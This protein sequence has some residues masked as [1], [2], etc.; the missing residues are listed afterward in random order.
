MRPLCRTALLL[1]LFAT[2][3]AVPVKRGSARHSAEQRA[4]NAQKL[5]D[6][7]KIPCS[8]VP[9]VFCTA[10][11]GC[12]QSGSSC[13]DDPSAPPINCTSLLVSSGAGVGAAE[14]ALLAAISGVKDTCWT[15]M[16][17]TQSVLGKAADSMKD[18]DSALKNY[19][20]SIM[21]YKKEADKLDSMTA[22]LEE[23]KKNCS[24]TPDP[25][26]DA[27]ILE[28]EAAIAKQNAT[29]EVKWIETTLEEKK[30]QLMEAEVAAEDKLVASTLSAPAKV[31]SE[32][33]AKITAAEAS[34]E[35]AIAFWTLVKNACIRPAVMPTV[36]RN[37]AGKVRSRSNGKH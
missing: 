16:Q 8:Q 37:K 32:A 19:N 12:K 25:A 10:D 24:A 11:A 18:Y 33:A 3:Q 23:L 21:S 20:S 14:K 30:M 2:G 34:K 35:S 26:C 27:S 29:C 28:M 17:G 13:V 4:R 9:D 1:A 15:T 6:G 5:F 36:T 31:F 22:T 7:A